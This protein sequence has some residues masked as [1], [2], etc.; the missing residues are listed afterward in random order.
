M[1][2]ENRDNFLLLVLYI[3]KMPFQNAQ[4]SDNIL[5]F[6]TTFKW[7]SEKKSLAIGNNIQSFSET[8]IIIIPT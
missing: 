7:V 4:Q 8:D 5:F 1:S 3:T 6:T 2:G